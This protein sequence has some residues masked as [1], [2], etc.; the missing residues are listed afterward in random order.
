MPI[1]SGSS[2]GLTYIKEVTYG[3]TPATPA[4]KALRN[5]GVTLGLKRDSIQSEELRSDRQLVGFRLGNKQVGGG[6]DIELAY[7]DFDDM[8]EAALG[9][10]WITNVL[11]AGSVRRSFTIE[12]F[13]T[14]LATRIRYTGCEVN[15]LNLTIA[16]NSQVKGSISFVGKDQDSNNAMIAGSTYPAPTNTQVFDSFIGT[17]KEGGTAYGSCTQIE[18]SIKNGIEPNFVIG[19]QTTASNS[20]GQSLVTGTV[21][22]FF[23]SVAMLNKFINETS[24]SLEFELIDLAGNKLKV[25]LPNIKYTGGQPDVNGPGAI[26]LALPF[27]A[28][29]NTAEASQIVITRTPI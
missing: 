7:G 15:E 1:A 3:V 26:S 23:E 25:T 27:Q 5:T 8:L 24:S 13:F 10:T 12:R 4:L 19:S 6:V 20:I 28:L 11:K 16:P 2:H 18:L 21:T 17:I 9:G 14:D 29:Y 22:V